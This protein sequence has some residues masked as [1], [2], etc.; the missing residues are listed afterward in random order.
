MQASPYET[1]LKEMTTEE[2][3]HKLQNAQ[4]GMRYSVLSFLRM[5]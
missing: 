1:T 4:K 2:I 3:L 5:V